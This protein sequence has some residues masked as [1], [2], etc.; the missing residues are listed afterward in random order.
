MS[1]TYDDWATRDDNAP[2]SDEQRPTLEQERDDFLEQRER[3]QA[4]SGGWQPRGWPAGFE[5]DAGLNEFLARYRGYEIRR[6]PS[7]APFRWEFAHA[8]YDGAPEHSYGPPADNRCGYEQT[9]VDCC[10]EIDQQ[11]EEGTE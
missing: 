11:I 2:D 5:I 9:L 7:Y 3:E 6:A 10:R 4:E 1:S 8:D